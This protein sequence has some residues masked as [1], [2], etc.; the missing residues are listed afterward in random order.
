MAQKSNRLFCEP[1]PP[2]TRNEVI[3]SFVQWAK[4]DAGRTTLSAADGIA[5]F[6]SQQY[7]CPRRR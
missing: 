4:V 5:T 6:L 2:P 3:A 7:R 1:S